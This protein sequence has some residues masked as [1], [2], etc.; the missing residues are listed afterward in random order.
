MEA[1]QGNVHKSG[2]KRRKRTG[3]MLTEKE[4]IMTEIIGLRKM[5]GYQIWTSLTM[6][7]TG[8]STWRKPRANPGQ[9]DMVISIKE[10][11]NKKSK[12]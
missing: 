7:S 5:P 2:T 1:K 6:F 12:Q 11:L 3:P 8:L 10:I 9:M 4:E